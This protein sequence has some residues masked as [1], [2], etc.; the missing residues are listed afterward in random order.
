MF[1]SSF[2]HKKQQTHLEFVKLL[3]NENVVS[4]FWDLS[5]G[6]VVADRE[7]YST[8]PASLMEISN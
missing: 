8:S 6:S 2:D 7:L 4:L 5:Y 3:E 1:S